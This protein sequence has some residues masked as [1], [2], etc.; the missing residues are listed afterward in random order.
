MTQNITQF[1]EFSICCLFCLF[2]VVL[3]STVETTRSRGLASTVRGKARFSSG[4]AKNVGPFKKIAEN[5]ER[6]TR[7]KAVEGVIKKWNSF[8]TFATLNEDIEF[9]PKEFKALLAGDIDANLF[10]VDCL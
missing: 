3:N 8:V 7:A 9:K 6:P 2:V 10:Q 4:K 5:S 1:A